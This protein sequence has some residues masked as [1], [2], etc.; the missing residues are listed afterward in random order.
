MRCSEILLVLLWQFVQD[1]TV[2]WAL[3]NLSSHQCVSIRLRSD[4][5]ETDEWEQNKLRDW[6]RAESWDWS[7]FWAHKRNCVCRFGRTFF[8][9]VPPLQSIF[10]MWTPAESRE[11]FTGVKLETQHLSAELPVCLI[12]KDDWIIMDN[13]F[14]HG[15]H[16][17]YVHKT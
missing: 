9:V 5:A 6:W 8:K 2:D 1:K 15:F 10:H 16:C 12:R 3:K 14:P 17:S 7:V 4:S 11:N 13:A